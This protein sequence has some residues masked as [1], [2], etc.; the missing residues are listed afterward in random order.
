MEDRRPLSTALL[1]SA[2]ASETFA[3]K[4]VTVPLRKKHFSKPVT[5]TQHMVH[6]YHETKLREK[7]EQHEQLLKGENLTGEERKKYT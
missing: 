6:E 7:I 1:L 3:Q 5:P 4:T 2:L